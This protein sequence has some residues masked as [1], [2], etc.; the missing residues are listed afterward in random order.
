MTA[1]TLAR[2]WDASE[3]IAGEVVAEQGLP[4]EVRDGAATSRYLWHA[5]LLVGIIE[6]D[7]RR[8]RYVYGDDGRLLAVHRD[9]GSWAS[10][11]Y[12]AA[13]RLI[14]A[15]RPEGSCA[16]VYDGSG[17]LL[18]T[19]RGDASPFAYRWQDGRVVA[20]S[21]DREQSR[22]ERDA[23][24]RLVGLAQVVDGVGVAVRFTFDELGRLASVDYPGW[25]QVVSFALDERGRPRALSWNGREVLRFG[26]DDGSRLAHAEGVD[27][28]RDE[29]WHEPNGGRPTRQVITRPAGGAELWRTELARDEAF[30]L[31]RDGE[32]S[33]EYDDSGRLAEAREGARR[34]R[35]HHDVQD[36]PLDA[37]GAPF[38]V[39]RDAAGRL[40][41][42]REGG[43]ERVFRHDDAGNLVE[44]LVDGERV[45]RC[46]YDHK[47]RLV[48]KAGPAGTER[49]VY[50]ADD[51]LLAVAD[52]EGRPLLI[53]LRLPTGV[54]GMIDFRGDARGRFVRLLCDVHGNLLF[55]STDDG[56]VE[57]PFAADPYGV[58]LRAPTSVPYL[59][60]G[61]VFHADLGLY[62]V[63]CRWYAP[64]LRQF[65][66]PDSY[67]GAPDDERLV[68]PFL[69]AGRQRMARAQ[70]LGEW[71]RRPR[72]RNRYAYCA[73][74]PVNRFDPDGHWS[75]GGVLLSLLGVFWTLPNTVFGLAAEVTCLLGE[76]VRW[77]VWLFSGG[78]VTWQT[79]GFD[80]AASSNLDAFALVFK[81]GWLGSFHELLGIT[82]GNV[83]FINGEY[84]DN[85]RWQELRDPLT[86]TAYQGAVTIPKAQALFEHELRHVNQYSLFGPFFHVGLPAWG[87]YEWDLILNGGYRSSALEADAKAHGGW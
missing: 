20:A 35:Y 2:A 82:F 19:L 3:P 37:D 30:R 25:S 22:F 83:I 38:D 50:G 48:L 81:G 33:Y 77:L 75:F 32:R 78:H 7:G 45:A 56:A 84:Q 67:T 70:V 5:G 18:R 71:L 26:T 61:R 23:R 10:Y 43:R 53:Y 28:L 27:G 41:L 64:G 1:S 85:P 54:V 68:N 31:V 57:G 39:E 46:A 24:G 74:D 15:T 12:D 87:I 72:L 4:L 21:S 34:W 8:W 49:Y 11:E 52:G 59:H 47:G 55:A 16:H 13:G 29:I 69:E 79:P 6:P 66:T 73:N 58:P 42:A 9:G 60:R 65:L 17:R 76:V 40:R 62:R 44:A 63:G 80:V 86:P 36:Q 51:G 14:R